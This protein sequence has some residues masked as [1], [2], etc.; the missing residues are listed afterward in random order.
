MM[1][2]YI[3]ILLTSAMLAAIAP[4]ATNERGSLINLAETLAAGDTAVFT[5]APKKNTFSFSREKWMLLGTG[6]VLAAVAVTD[7]ILASLA[8][9]DAETI[10]NN[11]YLA[12]T[13]PNDIDLAY[14]EYKSTLSKASFYG[15]KSLAFYILS[16]TMITLTL[17][18]VPDARV[19]IAYTPDNTSLGFT[20][21]YRW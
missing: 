8:L 5:Y 18:Y 10:Y 19:S 11:R 6:A 14:I 12:G 15:Y 7:T 2:K 1:K 16:G 3:S 20:Y 17:I 9:N 4:G 13:T 21:A